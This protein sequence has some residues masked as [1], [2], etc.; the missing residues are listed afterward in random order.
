MKGKRFLLILISVFILAMVAVPTYAAVNDQQKAEIEALNK[1]IVDLQK[2]IVDKYVEA[3]EITKQ[4]ADLTKSNIDQA[5][6]YRQQFTQQNGSVAPVPGY[7]PGSG[8]GRGYCGGW[9]ANAG[10]YYGGRW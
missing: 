3:G 2:Q 7:G 9:G 1:Q 10:G 6:Q 4:Q 8:Y 5:E